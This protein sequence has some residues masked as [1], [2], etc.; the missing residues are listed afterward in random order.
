MRTALY[1]HFDAA[2]ALLY[3]GISLDTIRRTQQHQQGARWY[4]QIARIE[5]SWHGTREDA[6]YFEAEAILDEVPTFNIA[7]PNRRTFQRR[8]ISFLIVDVASGLMDGWYFMRHDAREVMAYMQSEAP[9]RE[10]RMRECSHEETFPIPDSRFWADHI[11]EVVALDL[12]HGTSGR[13]A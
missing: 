11:D 5:I 6:L 1:R 3:V 13:G 9:G 4:D 10:L 7:T 12:A 8:D 2:G